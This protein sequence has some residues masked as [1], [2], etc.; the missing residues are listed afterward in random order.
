M[1]NMNPYASVLYRRDELEFVEGFFV[2][3]S[4]VASGKSLLE[5]NRER[6]S[7]NELS[8]N[9][10]ITS[11]DSHRRSDRRR[12]EIKEVSAQQHLRT[13]KESVS[14]MNALD[15]ANNELEKFNSWVKAFEKKGA[16]IVAVLD[17]MG[18]Q[19][20]N[21]CNLLREQAYNDI[22]LLGQ[23]VKQH[24][25]QQH[26]SSKEVCGRSN[27]STQ[28]HVEKLKQEVDILRSANRE[29]E[30]EIERHANI[31]KQMQDELGEKENLLA[32]T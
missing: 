13:H 3:R 22:Q 11:R 28:I 26:F 27:Q 19:K 31:I 32:A 21:E 29:K 25:R 2:D 23:E 17:R 6:S 7:P 14:C 9:L 15:V 20:D 24:H 16:S 1:A 18:Q 4:M 30:A 12:D 10:T 8:M 5:P